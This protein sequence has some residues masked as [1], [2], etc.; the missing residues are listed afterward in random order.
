MRPRSSIRSPIG[1]D[2]GAVTGE[3]IAV[4]IAA[5]LVAIR[6]RGIEADAS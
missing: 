6:R 4:S 1:L 2:I 3:E 5:E